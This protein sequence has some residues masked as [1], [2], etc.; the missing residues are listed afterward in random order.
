MSCP[1]CF[2]RLSRVVHCSKPLTLG[3]A[4]AGVNISGTNAEVMPGQWEFQ[5][6]PCEGIQSTCLRSRG[7]P[8][9]G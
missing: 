4:D 7:P 2:C 9:F 1:P 8:P 3:V 6:G 5:V